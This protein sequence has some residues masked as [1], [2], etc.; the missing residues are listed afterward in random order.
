MRLR[1]YKLSFCMVFDWLVFYDRVHSFEQV[2]RHILQSSWWEE[3]RKRVESE[4]AARVSRT[5][6]AA[7][8]GRWLKRARAKGGGSA[9]STGGGATAEAM[10]IWLISNSQTRRNRYISRRLLSIGD[11]PGDIR[12]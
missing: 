5:G 6:Q 8:A 1:K 4:V 10:R 11:Y 2:S 12:A 9:A 7:S 3:S